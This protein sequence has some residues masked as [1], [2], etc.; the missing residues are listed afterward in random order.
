ME[1]G[2]SI[3]RAKNIAFALEFERSNW[4]TGSVASDDFYSQVSRNASS[5]P[6]GT[7]L[8]VQV[9][10]NAS[11][12]SLPPNTALSRIMFVSESLNGSKIPALAYVL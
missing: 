11:A 8:K 10:V 2:I 1:A 9:N 4:A 5:A 3:G 7:L 12:Y 6:G